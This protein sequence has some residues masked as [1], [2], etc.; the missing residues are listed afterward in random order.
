M[1]FDDLIRSGVALANTLT[2][3]L[4]A[5]VQHSSWLGNDMDGDDV[6]SDPISRP[7]LI[8][9]RQRLHQTK[10]NELVLTRAKIS[11]LVPTSINSNDRI[12]LPDGTTGPIVDIEGLLDPTTNLPY[13]PEVWIGANSSSG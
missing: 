2:T 5:N 10:S 9:Q 8:E 11:F 12:I 3:S 6:Y 4:Q 13:L 1:A 7:A